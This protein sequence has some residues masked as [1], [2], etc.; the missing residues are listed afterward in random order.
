M[1]E[2]SGNGKA[3]RNGG[4]GAAAGGPWHWLRNLFRRREGESQLRETIEELI[5]EIQEQ[6]SDE[7]G[8]PAIG[9]DERVMLGTS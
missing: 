7:E 2:A 1:S 3:L 5:G 4:S 6:E 8:A 9:N